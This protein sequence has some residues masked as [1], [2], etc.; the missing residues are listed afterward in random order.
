MPNEK[1]QFVPLIY[2]MMTLPLLDSVTDDRYASSYITLP[3]NQGQLILHRL[4]LC[5]VTM[6]LEK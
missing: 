4:G 3:E 6:Q 5:L 2:P 1:T